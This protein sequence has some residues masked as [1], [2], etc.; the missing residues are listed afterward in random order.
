MVCWMEQ[1]SS[2]DLSR[3][4]ETVSEATFLAVGRRDAEY[5]FCVPRMGTG[6]CDAR[7]F[8]QEGSGQKVKI[9]LWSVFQLDYIPRLMWQAQLRGR[10]HWM[11]APTPECESQ[12]NGFSFFVDAGDAGECQEQFRACL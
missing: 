9:T 8:D 7:E 4:A 5:R 2:R 1:L 12:C 11:V 10:K 3:A 6:G